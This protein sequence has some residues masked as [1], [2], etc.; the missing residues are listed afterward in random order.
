LE[1]RA[2][3]QR[4]NVKRRVDDLPISDGKLAYSFVFNGNTKHVLAFLSGQGK[5]RLLH[6]SEIV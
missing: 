5:G 3:Q 1:G 6:L 2:I 4:L